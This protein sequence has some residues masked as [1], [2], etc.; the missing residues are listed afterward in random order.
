M[1]TLDEILDLAI[2]IE[3]N[4]EKIYRRAQQEVPNPALAS[5]LLW[6]AEDEAKHE[7]WFIQF[8]EKANGTLKDPRM[9]DM[10]RSILQGVLGDRAFSIAESDFSRIDDLNSL[11]ELSIEFER[12][13]VLF[14]EMLGGFISD[15]QVLS[16]LTQI[17][18]EENRHV[19]LLEEFLGKKGPLPMAGTRRP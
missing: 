11:L 18:E 5:M 4:G 15:E 9:D 6:L 3:K 16:Q 7:K 19:Q 8:R 13:T 2:Q 12:D 14:Y 17:V 1:F 10:G